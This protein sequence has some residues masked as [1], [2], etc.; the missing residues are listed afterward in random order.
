MDKSSDREAE[1]IEA[2]MD[3]MDEELGGECGDGEDYYDALQD[4]DNDCLDDDTDDFWED[5]ADDIN[6]EIEC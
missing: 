6:D 3:C 5:W 4:C 2:C 1:T